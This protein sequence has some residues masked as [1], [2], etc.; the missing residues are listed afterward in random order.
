MT[1][2]QKQRQFVENLKTARSDT[3]AARAAGYSHP[4][5]AAAR[6]MA[7]PH[8]RAAIN[9]QNEAAA[10]RNDISR[11]W[12]IQKL[13]ENHERASQAVPVLDKTG[14]PTGEYRF[15]AS[16]CNRAL[17]LIGKDIGMFVERK[18]VTSDGEPLPLLIMDV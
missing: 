18:D 16:A 1:M 7:K 5:K 9:A 12:V 8:V 4:G 15:D 14:N 2:T 6:L 13:K 17:E 3:D 10:I 11:D